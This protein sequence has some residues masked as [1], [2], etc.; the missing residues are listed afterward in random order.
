M[1]LP[2]QHIQKVTLSVELQ[3]LRS[4]TPNRNIISLILILTSFEFV[5]ILIYF[6]LLYFIF[7]LP[8]SVLLFSGS[9]HFSCH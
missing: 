4:Y 2:R 7:L 9:F 1:L 8:L 6:G 3:F 5:L